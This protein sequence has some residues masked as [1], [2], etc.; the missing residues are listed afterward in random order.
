MEEYRYR[1]ISTNDSSA[2]YGNCEVCKKP[3]S[4]IFHQIEARKYSG[5]WTYAECHNFLDIKNA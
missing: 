1:L 5:G 3:A 2:K 4:E